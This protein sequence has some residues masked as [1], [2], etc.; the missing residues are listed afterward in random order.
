MSLAIAV[1]RGETW[2]RIL[3]WVVAR[4]GHESNP[5]GMTRLPKLIPDEGITIAQK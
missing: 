4:V 3:L 2:G 5:A 1:Y